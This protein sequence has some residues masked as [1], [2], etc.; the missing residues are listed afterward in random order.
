MKTVIIIGAGAAGLT[1]AYEL[2]KDGDF[3]PII[4]ECSGDIG[5]LSKTINYKGNRIDIGGHRFFSKEDKI[6]DWWLNILPLAEN[7]GDALQIKYQNKSKTILPRQPSA[8]TIEPAGKRMLI[9]NRKSRI[10]YNGHFFDYPVTLNADTIRKL[11]MLE[12]FKIAASYLK[13]K[14]QNKKDPTTL[15]DFLIGNFGNKL[16]RTFFKDYTEK[17]WGVPCNRI[18][19]AWGMQRIKDLSLTKTLLHAIKKKINPPNRS[20]IHQKST[21][22]SLIEQFLYPGLGPGELWEEVAKQVI[23]K[24][25]EIHLNQKV[26]G[27]TIDEVKKLA[28]AIRSVDANGNSAM[29]EA[30]YF[31]STMPV[32]ELINSLK[33]TTIIPPGVFDTANKLEYRDFVIVGILLEKALFKNPEG[34]GELLDNWIY[35]QDKNVSIGRIQF[36]N[37]WSPFMVKDPETIWLG[38]EYFCSKGDALWSLSDEQFIQ[39]GINELIKIGFVKEAKILDSTLI[40]IEKAYP[41][42]FGSYANFDCVIEFINQ[43]SNLFLIGRNGMHKYNNADHSMLT[44]MEAVFN[45]KHDIT[46]K[47]NIWNVNTEEVYN[48]KKS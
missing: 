14:I 38:L 31:I 26:T 4:I 7:D 36:F 11:G 1:A 41:G 45:I 25:G 12:L 15:E 23:D 19:A 43:F 2:L 24:G 3:K 21:S 22:T 30:D 34:A 5:G 13:A 46:N 33:P 28:T 47:E 9:R 27:L 32:Q 44:A 8:G 6:I 18:P 10:F 16:Y 37:N 35:I 48:E 42:Y 39:L 20:N 40:R 17:V 29:F